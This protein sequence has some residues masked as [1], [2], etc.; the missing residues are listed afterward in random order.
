MMNRT[1]IT[2]IDN[3]RAWWEVDNERPYWTLYRGSRNAKGADIIARNDTLDDLESSWDM[4][5]NMITINS[6]EGGEFTVLR[7]DKPKGNF[8]NKAVVVLSHALAPAGVGSLP[9]L[10][11]VAGSPQGIQAY[12]A[13]EVE[14]AKESWEL[15]KQVEDLS[16]MINAKQEGTGLERIFNKL[17]ESDKIGTIL[18]VVLAK[19]L[20][21]AGAQASH[22]AVSGAPGVQH[23][24]DAFQYDTE[25][26]AAA[27]ERIRAHFP[28]IHGTLD[29]LA[30]F[31]EKNPSMAKSLFNQMS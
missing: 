28:D 26:V 16:A 11:F 7:T 13:G 2:S 27:L 20:T 9:G 18:D 6:G 19:F 5:E 4:L 23:D 1:A 30:G 25:R 3:L 29:K 24:P 17:L 10:P 21:P 14:K 12:I 31:I 22:V 15:R 8:G